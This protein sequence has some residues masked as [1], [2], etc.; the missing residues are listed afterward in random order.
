MDI[1]LV[2]NL[3]NKQEHLSVDQSVQEMVVTMVARAEKKV[4]SLDNKMV[5]KRAAERV[6]EKDY[7]LVVLRDF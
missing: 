7:M 6:A 5:Q 4:D 3:D 2:E 1:V